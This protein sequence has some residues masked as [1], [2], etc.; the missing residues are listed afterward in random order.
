[1]RSPSYPSPNHAV[2]GAPQITLGAYNPTSAASNTHLVTLNG[3]HVTVVSKTNPAAVLGTFDLENCIASPNAR[4]PSHV[5][6]DYRGN[7]WVFSVLGQASAGHHVLCIYV[8]ITAN[9]FGAYNGYSYNMSSG[10]LNST[11][12]MRMAI[13]REA[14]AFTF[15]GLGNDLCVWDFTNAT[16]FCGASFNSGPL[17]WAPMTAAEGEMPDRNVASAASPT[18]GAVFF[19]AID[20][21]YESN[22]TTPTVDFIEVE[23]W[24]GINFNASTYN[25]WRYLIPVADFIKSPLLGVPTPDVQTLNAQSAVLMNRINFI[26]QRN[27]TV[28]TLTSNS[29]VVFWFELVW[30]KPSPSAAELWMLAQQGNISV[31]ASGNSAFLPTASMDTNGTIVL[32]MAISGESTYPSL[33]MTSRLAN[34]P[35]GQMRNLTMLASGQIGSTFS[36]GGSNWGSYWS[37]TTDP[38]GPRTFFVTGQV[39]LIASDGWSGRVF[40]VRVLGETI[41]RIWRAQDTCGQEVT[42]DQFIVAS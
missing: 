28:L 33:Y 17:Q 39:S 31:A 12:Y 42:C 38:S 29:S 40:R 36:T 35:L 9:V 41:R 24:Y 22:A 15:D 7:T 2:Q 1:M 27:A 10:T 18:A 23:H 21:E 6:W 13:W 5:A 26:K 16:F 20:D 3:I 30:A 4:V 25:A 11:D 34:D 32:A 37:V 19:R 14:Y 8:G